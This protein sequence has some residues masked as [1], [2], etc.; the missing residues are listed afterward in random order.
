MNIGAKA[1][2]QVVEGVIATAAAIQHELRDF[3]EAL[4]K[5]IDK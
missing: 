2:A 5:G 1:A 4:C 3:W